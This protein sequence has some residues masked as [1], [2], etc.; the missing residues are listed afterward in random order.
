M[1]NLL[2]SVALIVLIAVPAMATTPPPDPPITIKNLNSNV[3]DV[4]VNNPDRVLTAPEVDT[5]D[6]P[7]YQNGKVSN[8]NDWPEIPI[9]GMTYLKRGEVVVR[10][11]KVLSG[12]PGWRIRL[13]NVLPEL[14]D[15]KIEGPKV[16]YFIQVK[17]ART[18]GGFNLLSAASASVGNGMG[19]GAAPMGYTESTANPQHIITFVEIQ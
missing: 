11:L 6:I 19:T 2:L 18:S 5:L 12:I 4:Q 8:W 15:N 1:K 13:E 16:R 3:N 17:D 10:V 7:I 9:K 14:I